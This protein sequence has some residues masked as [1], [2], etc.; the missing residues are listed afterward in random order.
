M[1]SLRDCR[2]EVG[3]SAIAAAGERL[4]NIAKYDLV[5]NLKTTRALGLIF[6]PSILAAPTR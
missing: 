2:S 4:G 5:I 1:S 3:S 6:P